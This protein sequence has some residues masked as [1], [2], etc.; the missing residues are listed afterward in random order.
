VRDY[1]LSALGL[2]VDS[3]KTVATT[4]FSQNSHPNAPDSV[5]N[6]G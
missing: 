6:A 3:R 4:R 5:R 1:S 2:P